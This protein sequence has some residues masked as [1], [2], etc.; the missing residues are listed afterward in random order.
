MWWFTV[1]W[2]RYPA[3][4]VVFVFFSGCSSE[5]KRPQQDYRMCWSIRVASS[6]SMNLFL[7][8]W[9]GV[10]EGG[11]LFHTHRMFEL[12]NVCCIIF[13]SGMRTLW[14][15]SRRER[16][17]QLCPPLTYLWHIQTSSSATVTAAVWLRSTRV[18]HGPTLIILHWLK[19]SR[20]SLNSN[21]S[22]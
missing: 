22:E 17:L 7:K 9:V 1:C 13:K 14:T 18:H 12:C 6:T 10:C 15:Y 3:S 4:L 20:F 2:P 8:C 11:S 5:E 19:S 16:R 21:R